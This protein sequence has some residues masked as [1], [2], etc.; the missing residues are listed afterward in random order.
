MAQSL[1]PASRSM[2]K[3]VGK[4]SV[5]A[6]ILHSKMLKGASRQ[7]QSTTHIRDGAA[8]R[9]VRR[10]PCR[11]AFFS[12]SRRRL[13]MVLILTLV[14]TYFQAKS[15]KVL[16][17]TLPSQCMRLPCRFFTVVICSWRWPWAWKAI[18]GRLMAG[19]FIVLDSMDLRWQGASFATTLRSQE[20]TPFLM[21]RRKM[22][23]RALWLHR[24]TP[25]LH[26]PHLMRPKYGRR[27]GTPTWCFHRNQLVML[28]MVWPPCARIR[29]Q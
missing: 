12:M 1:L 7:P 10:T 5:L 13:A 19:A 9:E 15:S 11:A 4:L 18:H 25:P 3:S 17:W 16:L 22:I 6:L 26:L 23:S 20:R 8:C 14:R 21:R 2:V 24:S 29:H 28:E 27:M